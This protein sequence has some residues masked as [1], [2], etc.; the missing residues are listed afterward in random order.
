MG[1]VPM[2]MSVGQTA[3]G[4][5]D[6]AVHLGQRIP[7]DPADL[8][9]QPVGDHNFHMKMGL[10]KLHQFLRRGHVLSLSRIAGD[11]QPSVLLQKSR[12][13]A[14][15]PLHIH[16][17]RQRAVKQNPVVFSPEGFHLGKRPFRKAFRASFPA[18]GSELP[19][20]NVQNVHSRS[21]LRIIQNF[22]YDLLVH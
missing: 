21:H 17:L 4:M 18:P 6:P 16:A 12:Q 8:I 10:K 1:N 5:G 20:G 19:G 9:Q 2:G 3:V 22:L 14:Q 7:L 13:S 11:T 15:Q